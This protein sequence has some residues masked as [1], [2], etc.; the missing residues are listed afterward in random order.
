MVCWQTDR[1]RAAGLPV[2]MFVDEPALCLHGPEELAVSEEERLRPLAAVLSDARR[3]GAIAGL[4][5]CAARPFER[6]CRVEPD[7]VSF[8]AHEGLEPFFA[9]AEAR[10]FLRNGGLA[11]YG[12]IPTLDR[13]EGLD[14]A[15]IFG[16]WLATAALNGDPRELAGRAMVT[17]TCGLGLL[18]GSAVAESFR[19][20]Q[21]VGRLFG[22]LSGV[23]EEAATPAGRSS[24]LGRA[25]VPPLPG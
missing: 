17:A 6:M 18:D 9:N 1:L 4:H 21:A 5:C 10:K 3:R 15:A 24:K 12:L 2:L 7:I 20:A 19:L 16:R 13:L 11:A 14:P 8:D 23:E 25:S 22:R